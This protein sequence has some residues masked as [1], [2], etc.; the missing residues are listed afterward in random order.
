M[1]HVQSFSRKNR[2]TVRMIKIP[3]MFKAWTIHDYMHISTPHR[4]II[5]I[6]GSSTEQDRETWRISI[7]QLINRSEKCI[8]LTK[9]EMKKK[10]LKYFLAL[11]HFRKKIKK[12]PFEESSI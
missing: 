5:F 3:N 8:M 6:N 7:N 4:P 10:H 1:Y 2:T 12:G 9:L 11:Q